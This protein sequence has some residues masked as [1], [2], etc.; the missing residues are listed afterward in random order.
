V[1]SRR[2]ER[3]ASSA[4]GEIDS[5]K[6]KGGKKIMAHV[7]GEASYE[8]LAPPAMGV[9]GGPEN[10][11]VQLTPDRL[12]QIRGLLAEPFDPA[13]IKWRVT[14]T[15]TQQTKHGLQRRGQ[16]AAYADQRAYTDR[17]NEVFGEWGWT[18]NYDVQVAQNF[19]RRA[20]GD[21]TET[22]IAA[23]VVVVSTVTVHGLGSHTGVGEEWADD[24]NAA[25]RAEAQAF[26][27]ACACFGLG[28]YLYDLER[29]WADLDQHNRPLHT[30][31]LPVWALPG[32]AQRR[33]EGE[34]KR[35]GPGG[36]RQSLVQQ[37]TL[38]KVQE[39]CGKVGHSLALFVLK[40]Y[41]GVTDP[42]RAG[43]AKLTAVFEKL[44]DIG[45]GIDRLR[46]AAAAID[47]TRYS[48]LCRELGLPS[49]AIDDI[50]DRDA[51]KR[52]LARVEGEAAARNGA[53]SSAASLAEARGGLLQAARKAA[54]R[55]GK[56]LED[57]IAEASDGKLSLSGLKDLTEADV[58]MVTAAT[59]RIAS[60]VGSSG[61]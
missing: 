26:K 32:G 28:R 2:V 25:T 52:L 57:V 53:G 43:F 47:D 60:G 9:Q 58:A 61:R 51:L 24:Q 59:A 45:N 55:S 54:D 44:T 8:S 16:L 41:A 33:A 37:E 42:E 14:A 19:E 49:E 7:N 36:P 50:P 38:A 6:R 39:L 18:R 40:K 13:E 29:T 17:L 31:K 30:P 12:H 1:Q 48:A 11:G 5:T 35:N 56:R 21:K 23:K 46:R 34:G 4:G 15:S 10:H 22:A 27:R 20:P 3:H